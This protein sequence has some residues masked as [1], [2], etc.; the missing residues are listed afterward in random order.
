M[1]LVAREPPFEPRLATPLPVS[2]AAQDESRAAEVVEVVEAAAPPPVLEAGGM[3][4][5]KEPPRRSSLWWCPPSTM[6]TAHRRLPRQ[7]RPC[8]AGWRKRDPGA[9]N[10]YSVYRR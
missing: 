2:T 5:D 9:G 7:V 8:A 6:V 4:G 10:S 3:A 1:V